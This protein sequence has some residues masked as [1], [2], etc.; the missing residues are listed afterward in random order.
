MNAEIDSDITPGLLLRAYSIGIFPMAESRD[1]TDIV[2][3]DPQLRGTIPLDRL[4][5]SRSLAKSF[6]KSPLKIGINRDFMAVVRACAQRDETWISDNIIALYQGLHDM[7]HAHSVEIWN[8]KN[9][10]GGLYGVSLGA[11]FFGESMFSNQRDVS[12]YAL[13]A[14]VARLNAG[15]FRLLDTQFVTPHLSTLGAIEI[16]RSEYR[17]RLNDALNHAADFFALSEETGTQELLQLST[18]TS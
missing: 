6:R 1:A 7:G 18:Q 16:S 8:E 11:A 3:V 5:I 4:H 9:L 10:V 15:C 17:T 2:W 14:L 12:K 13:I